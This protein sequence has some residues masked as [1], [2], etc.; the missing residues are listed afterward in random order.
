MSNESGFNWKYLIPIYGLFVISKS[1]ST[2]KNKLIVLNIFFSIIVFAIIGSAGE[3]SKTVP[4]DSNSQVA[5]Q[6]V[7]EEKPKWKIGDSIKTEKFD[8][9]IGTV[10]TKGRIG[11]EY[12]NEKAADG[13]IFIAVNFNYKNITKEPIGAY[14]VP[15]VKIIDPNGTQYDE[16]DSATIYYQTEINLNKKITSDINPG[17]T[18]KDAT[19][20]EVSKELWNSKGWKL[21]I[22]ADDDIEIDIK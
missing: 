9:K 2:S 21:V 7:S 19:V 1:E 14:S 6:K 3:D 12:L 13:A 4:G 15:K 10:T 18:Q 20:F 8:I 16:A 5:D 17:I 11:N 22:K